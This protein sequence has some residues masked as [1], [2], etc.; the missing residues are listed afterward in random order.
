MPQVAAVALHFLLKA[1]EQSQK[2]DMDEMLKSIAVDKEIFDQPNARVDS[3]KMSEL[4][5][6]AMQR[7]CDPHLPLYLGEMVNPNSLGLLGYLLINA[8]TVGKMLEKLHQYHRLIGEHLNF[9]FSET[10]T[11]YRLAVS[12]GGN[13]LIPMPVFQAQIHLSAI[14]S[15]IRQVSGRQVFPTRTHFQHARPDDLHEYRRLFGER[16]AFVTPENAL[17][18]SKD[19]LEIALEFSNRSMLH[20]FE[21]EAEKVLRDLSDDTLK[22]RVQKHILLNLGDSS[23]SLELTAKSLGIGLRTLQNGLA[24][25]GAGFREILAQVRTHMAEH[26]L[27]ETSLD[28]ETIALYMGYA[29]S[30]VFIRA[31][32]QWKGMT[33]NQFRLHERS[34]SESVGRD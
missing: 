26:Y 19:D 14:L 4:L 18:F 25:E 12:I 20:Y 17:F 24:S 9:S 22:A 5:H 3:K 30:P 15:L 13:P 6:F 10:G 27:L 21:S 16:V 2:L 1:L 7:T 31:F 34:K 11:R 23:L 8:P 32:K 29:E 33:P 28:V